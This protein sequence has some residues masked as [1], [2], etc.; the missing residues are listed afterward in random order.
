[1]S[2]DE[3]SAVRQYLPHMLPAIEEAAV[4]IDKLFPGAKISA[5]DKEGATFGWDEIQVKVL[6]RGLQATYPLSEDVYVTIPY[7]NLDDFV[8]NASEISAAARGVP[9]LGG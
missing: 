7:H 1:M 9:L 3:K 6:S 8:W 5:L 2:E 4:V